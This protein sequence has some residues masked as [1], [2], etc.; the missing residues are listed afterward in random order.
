MW[1]KLRIRD[2]DRIMGMLFLNSFLAFL[3]FSL[4]ALGLPRAAIAV[5]VSFILTLLLL[6]IRCVRVWLECRSA[7]A[8]VGPLSTDEKLKARSKLLKSPTQAPNRLNR[9]A[10]FPPFY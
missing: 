1:D 5:S 8:P 9:T 4:L 6:G 3:G 7:R 2:R 10:Y